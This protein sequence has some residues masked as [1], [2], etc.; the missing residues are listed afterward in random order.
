MQKKNPVQLEMFPSGSRH[1]EH[2]E[3]RGC[4][5]FSMRHYEKTI[6]LVM[7]FL[8]VGVISFTLGVKS[9]KRNTLLM[10]QE[11]KTLP[12][13]VKE[14]KIKSVPK[15]SETAYKEIVK[16]QGTGSEVKKPS[17]AYTIQVATFRA[18]KLAQREADEL[19][20]MGMQVM[21]LSKDEYSQLCVGRFINKDEAT[22]TLKRLR[23]RYQDCFVRRL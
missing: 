13:D 3:G 5:L 17:G 16:S 18:R 4:S 1:S 10:Q 19:K 2:D 11:P 23:N 12:K 6:I 15:Q 22:T 14:E 7:T 21:V 20:K 8:T 9:G